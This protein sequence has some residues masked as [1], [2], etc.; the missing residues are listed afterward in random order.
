MKLRAKFMITA[1]AV[2][3]VP[4]AIAGYFAGRIGQD[5]IRR[6]I[7]AQE[8]T[9]A[10]QVADY[11]AAEMA[12]V[13]DTL[14]VQSRVLDLTQKGT[15]APTPERL[16]KFL[17]FVYHQKEVFS[18]VGVYDE[19]GTPL[20]PPAFQERPR[21]NAALG[22]HDAMTAD[23]AAEVPKRA[24]LAEALAHNVATGEVFLAGRDASPQLIVA[25]R[26]EP[27]PDEAPQ[28]ILAMV[29]LRP[30]ARYLR[31]LETADR[32]LMLLDRASRV[33]ASS[34]R[35]SQTALEPRLFPNGL[36]GTLPERPFV[37]AYPSQDGTRVVGAFAPA[38][39]FHL[40]VATER[41]LSQA[42]EPVTRMGFATV[43][44]VSI[45]GVLAALVAAWLGRNLSR[46]I[47][48]LG[49]AARAVSQGRL[50]TQLQVRTRDEIGDLAKAF[51]AMTTSLDAARAEILRQ[52]REIKNWNR[53]L[54]QR[55]AEKTRELQQAQDVLLRS[56]S[57][58][59]IGVLGS[60]VAHEIN[61][62]LA[63]VLGLSQLMLAD[64]PEDHPWRPMVEDVEGQ[65]LRIRHIVAN[66]LRLS[67]RQA[68]EDF[69]LVDLSR[70][71]DDALELA[72]PSS[73][74]DAH[75]VIDKRVVSPSPPIRGSAFQLQAAIIHI[76]KN[77]R[78]AMEDGGGTL[79][80]ETSLP[81]A[82][83]LCLRVSDTGRGIKP[84]HLPRIFDPFFT[85]KQKWDE[86]G[87]GLAVVHKIVEDHGGQ[88][89]A[90]SRVGYGTSFFLTFPLDEGQAT[91]T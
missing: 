84:E 34:D 47:I 30:L 29:S 19:R 87:M 68:G 3:A 53:N 45:S 83:L 85:T 46:R 73:L 20:A 16:Q 71:I 43:Y 33:V 41:P 50:D 42:M 12:A 88:I 63:G 24:P 18:V 70:V 51:N 32:R 35:E 89:R 23:D 5:A 36:P 6:S 15:E 86:T 82:K 91:L 27:M 56:R 90:E 8:Q 37:A 59:A 62:P 76:I 9:V 13:A 49:S 22:R 48:D 66:L 55:V 61:N 4:M 79:T 39:P 60:G 69:R 11:V 17:Q 67:Q 21:D 58:A 1:V 54:E 52:T 31:E 80:L 25:L 78:V 72:S 44:W 65:A 2:C 74:A 14:R 40:G 10:V 81:A 77:A 38:N 57:L 64:M 75:I 26:Y 7:E 28:L